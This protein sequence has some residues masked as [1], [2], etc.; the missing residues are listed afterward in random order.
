MRKGRFAEDDGIEVSGLASMGYSSVQE[1]KFGVLMGAVANKNHKVYLSGIEEKGHDYKIDGDLRQR[2][3]QYDRDSFSTGYAYQRD[4]HEAE[5]NYNNI[6]T[7]HSG[8]PALPMDIM[9]VRGG[10]YNGKYKWDLGDGR[11]LR[12]EGFYQKMRHLMN[13]YTLRTAGT[14]K[15]NRTTVE[16]GGYKLAWDMPFLDGDLSLGFDA[17]KSLN[18]ANVAIA[19]MGGIDIHFFNDT[20]RDRYSAF[21]EWSKELTENLSMELGVRYSHVWSNTGD[22]IVNMGPKVADANTFNA[23]DHKRNFDFVDTDAIFRYALNDQFDI[24]LGLARKNRA[25]SYQALYLWTDA[26]SVGG[27]ADGNTYIGNL[28]LKHETAYQFDL[29][30]DWHT[31]RAYV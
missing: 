12:V 27:L 31:D 16:A 3:T 6:D 8:T 21:A 29:G 11:Q 28:N 30:L 14:Q 5:L 2:P 4:G 15:S 18:N 10:L 22:A 26:S 20:Q 1:G 25:P 19:M 7:G 13:N 9:Y 23:L 17:D 24:E